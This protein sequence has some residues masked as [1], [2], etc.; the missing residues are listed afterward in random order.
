MVDFG[1]TR[2]R[3][4]NFAENE[5]PAKLLRLPRHWNEHGATENH[6]QN[7]CS[8]S[9]RHGAISSRSSAA[10]LPHGRSRRAQPRALLQR[11]DG[12]AGP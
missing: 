4:Q 3:F 10:P 8:P 12:E 2:G 7:L 5:N 6:S 9:I 11:A 1:I